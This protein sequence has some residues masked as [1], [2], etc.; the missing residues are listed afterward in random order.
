MDRKKFAGA[1]WEGQ[2]GICRMTVP[3]VASA[4]PHPAP[5]ESMGLSCPIYN[6]VRMWTGTTHCVLHFLKSL[7]F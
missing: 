3:I 1:K 5:P 2:T 4:V 6:L 7:E